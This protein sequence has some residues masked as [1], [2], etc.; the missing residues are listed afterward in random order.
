[1]E[2]KAALFQSVAAAGYLTGRDGWAAAGG[3]GDDQAA[4]RGRGAP[5]IDVLPHVPGDKGS[6]AALPIVA[7]RGRCRRRGVQVIV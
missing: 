7:P 4:P 6:S 1:M 5:A 3:P 2:P